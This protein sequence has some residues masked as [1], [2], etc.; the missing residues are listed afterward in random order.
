VAQASLVN[1]ARFGRPNGMMLARQS[2]ALCIPASAARANG[3]QPGAVIAE[4]AGDAAM[5]VWA[6]RVDGGGGAARPLWRAL[7]RPRRRPGC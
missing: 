7:A 2:W 1:P 3:R 4:R 6:D 5:T